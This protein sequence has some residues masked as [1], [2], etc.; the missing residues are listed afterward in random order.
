[1]FGLYHTDGLVEEL[2]K[3]CPSR[4]STDVLLSGLTTFRI[5]GPADLVV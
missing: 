4:V 3:V 2:S 5:G 1:M